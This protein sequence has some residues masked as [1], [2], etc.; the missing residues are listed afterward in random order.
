MKAR[1]GWFRGGTRGKCGAYLHEASG[2]SVLHCGHPTALWPYYAVPPGD[3]PRQMLLSCG[4]GLGIAFQN[5]LM[6]Q[7]VVEHIVEVGHFHEDRCWSGRDD[8]SGVRSRRRLPE[9]ARRS[10]ICG[11]PSYETFYDVS[12]GR[13]S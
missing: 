11:F 13:A 1:A 2:W 5:L 7:L 12:K 6:A 9:S 4:L 3:K 10:L 8:G